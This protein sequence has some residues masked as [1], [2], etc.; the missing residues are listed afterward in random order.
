MWLVYILLLIIICE[1]CFHCIIQNVVCTLI[2]FTLHCPSL[3][4]AKLL[5]ENKF[6][7]NQGICT[8]SSQNMYSISLLKYLNNFHTYFQQDIFATTY[9]LYFCISNILTKSVNGTIDDLSKYFLKMILE[10]RFV[11]LMIQMIQTSM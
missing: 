4:F 1:P 9:I 8:S 3:L 10:C 11:H 2:F 6:V 5:S 7:I